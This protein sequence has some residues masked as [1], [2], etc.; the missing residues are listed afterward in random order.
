MTTDSIWER[1]VAPPLTALR[2]LAVASLA[3]IGFLWVA[4]GPL[5]RLILSPFYVTE[6]VRQVYSPNRSA[7][8]E[9]EVRKGGFGTVWTTR[10]H[11]RSTGQTQWTVYQTKDS[12]FVPPLRWV[13]GNTLVIGLPCDR[14]D[15]LSNPDDW[16]SITPRPNRVRVRFEH[17]RC[18]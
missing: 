6:V 1:Y 14:F 3:V 15:H 4:G 8:A 5:A 12:D 7:V 9:I 17:P 13:N 11:L 10:V 2:K 18:P 16:E